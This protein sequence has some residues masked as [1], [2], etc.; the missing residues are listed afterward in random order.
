MVLFSII[1]KLTTGNWLQLFKFIPITVWIIIGLIV[2]IWI[3]IIIYRK[4]IIKLEI[5][6]RT[7]KEKLE[8]KV[9]I[10]FEKNAYWE[11]KKD[12]SKE[13][14]YCSVCLDKDKKMIRMLPIPNITSNLW[15]CPVCKNKVLSAK[16]T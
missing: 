2:L 10:I 15:Q 8:S 1:S 16:Y 12:G 3:P 13:G 5:E 14:P 7:L 11:K 4:K 6:N 9:D